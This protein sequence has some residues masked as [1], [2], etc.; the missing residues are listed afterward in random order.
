MLNNKNDQPTDDIELT[1]EVAEIDDLELAE[2]EDKSMSKIKSLQAKLKACEAEKKQY[3][4]DAQRAKADFLNSK[5]RLEEDK[6]RTGERLINDH[7]EKLL[8]LCDSFSMAMSN[9][10]AWEAVDD[11]WRQGIEAIHTQLLGILKGY[12]VTEIDPLGEM[13]DPNRHEA[14]GTEDSDAESETVT[15]VIQRGYERNGDIIRPAKVMLS[16]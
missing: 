9:T 6:I 8:P 3:L 16:T 7:I 11:S 15:K 1:D 2:V 12:A 13:F 4:D 14:L 10:E 5:K